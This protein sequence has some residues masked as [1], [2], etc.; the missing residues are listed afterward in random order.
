MLDIIKEAEDFA[1][2]P[3]LPIELQ[4][5]IWEAALPK[6]PRLVALWLKN[7]QI[8]ENGN[9][10]EAPE[11]QHKF[12]CKN[13][14]PTTLL[15]ICHQSR[16]VALKKFVLQIKTPIQK[17]PIY[18]DPLVDTV[19]TYNF[20]A[21]SDPRFVNLRHLAVPFT[22][23]YDFPLECA[24]GVLG[25]WASLVTR[26]RNLSHLVDIVFIN[27]YGRCLL[28]LEDQ[29]NTMEFSHLTDSFRQG[30]RST[31]DMEVSLEKSL[32]PEWKVPKFYMKD[33]KAPDG[34]LLC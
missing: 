17:C 32:H 10:E 15:H 8:G 3:E 9:S 2:F 21:S 22:S 13:P 34:K 28:H 5:Q 12:L 33:L 31:W 16:E 14:P 1:L 23:D 30:L 27:H 19:Y 6:G 29:F 7:W 24:P 4:L 25:T 20:Y 11:D 26:L 18:I